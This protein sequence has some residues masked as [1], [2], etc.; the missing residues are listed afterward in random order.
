MYKEILVQ[1]LCT[2]YTNSAVTYF[3]DE[4]NKQFFSQFEEHSEKGLF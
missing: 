2:Y 1:L 3:D 4:K